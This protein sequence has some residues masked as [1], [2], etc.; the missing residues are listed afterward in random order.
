V[1]QAASTS[2]Q[3]KRIRGRSSRFAGQSRET[4]P[5]G[6][7]LAAGRKRGTPASRINH[8]LSRVSLFSEMT[9]EHEE[10]LWQLRVG[11]YRI[12]FYDVNDQAQEV[13]V[14]AVRHKPPHKT[15]EEIL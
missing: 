10:P 15:T 6:A 1:N 4:R 9:W 14:R 7:F 11:E 13:V 3:K 12:F 8:L 2:E 5:G